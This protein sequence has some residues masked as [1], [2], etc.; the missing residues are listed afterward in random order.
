MKRKVL[1]HKRRRLRQ[2]GKSLDSGEQSLLDSEYEA[3]SKYVSDYFK[4]QEIKTPIVDKIFN[5][6]RCKVSSP[7]PN[8]RDEILRRYIENN[9]FTNLDLKHIVF[10]VEQEKAIDFDQVKKIGKEKLEDKMEDAI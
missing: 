4:I 6:L 10:N 2:R 5:E 1:Q 7:A 8:Q 3:F 9:I